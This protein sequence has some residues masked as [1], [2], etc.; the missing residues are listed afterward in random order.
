LESLTT[1]LYL[2]PVFPNFSITMQWAVPSQNVILSAAKD[3]ETTEIL[4]FAGVQELL[5]S[6]TAALGCPGRFCTAE[7]GCAT[8]YS[9]T[10]ALLR[11]TRQAILYFRS[12]RAERGTLFL[13][14]F[15]RCDAICGAE[16]QA[17][18]YRP[19]N[20]Y[21]WQ[22]LLKFS[23][24]TDELTCIGQSAWPTVHKEVEPGHVLVW[25]GNASGTKARDS[26]LGNADRVLDARSSMGSRRARL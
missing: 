14:Q 1:E 15:S 8:S 6:G 21:H 19:V 23:R 26:H 4:R 20:P 2:L 10:A 3:L 5:L 9:W 16:R 18:F 24:P 12:S 22:A 7:G 17:G 13:A 11:M 25:V